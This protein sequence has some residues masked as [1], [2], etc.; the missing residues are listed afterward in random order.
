MAYTTT[1]TRRRESSL[2]RS[3]ISLRMVA[4]LDRNR[5]PTKSARITPA[6]YWTYLCAAALLVLAAAVPRVPKES[7]HLRVRPPSG[8]FGTTRSSDE[9]KLVAARQNDFALSGDA[10]CHWH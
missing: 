1:W 2:E 7:S 9:P 5:M 10:A 4:H 3:R 8:A 6:E